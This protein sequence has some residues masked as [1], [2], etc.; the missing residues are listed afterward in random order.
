MFRKVIFLI[1]PVAIL[2]GMLF[3]LQTAFG[4][5]IGQRTVGDVQACL[6][7]YCPHDARINCLGDEYYGVYTRTSSNGS[8][9]IDV[10][11]IDE[12]TGRGRRGIRLTPREQEA[13]EEFPAENTLV[14]SYY[15]ASVYRLTSG[16]WQVN[17]G[18]NREGKVYVVVFTGCPATNVHEYDFIAPTPAP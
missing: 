15:E 14:D 16:E 11:L 1:I 4:W 17:A 9:Y 18:P 8:C 6:P 10:V 3:G 13:V 12:D 5:N 2:L 7:C